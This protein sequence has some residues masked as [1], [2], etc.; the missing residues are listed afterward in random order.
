MVTTTGDRMEDIGPRLAAVE[1]DTR[2]I[3]NRLEQIQEDIREMRVEH[4]AEMR[5]MRAGHQAEM[6]EMR[7]AYQAE[8]REMRAE[9]QADMRQVNER[10]DQVN[11][12]FDQVNERFDQVNERFDRV[13]EIM[14]DNQKE[15][16]ARMERIFWGIL[17][18]GTT[19]VATLV[20]GFTLLIIQGG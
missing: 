14:I 3:N 2:N 8:M 1:S 4:Q 16:N 7:A 5:E 20:T 13:H 11:E 18:A 19:I 9:H 6:R 10:F 12:R 15:S 17:G